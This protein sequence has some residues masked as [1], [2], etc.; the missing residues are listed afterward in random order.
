[1]KRTTEFERFDSGIRKILSISRD[2]LKRR[3]EDWKKQRKA[4]KRAKS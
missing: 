1:M 2:E 3:E 4:K